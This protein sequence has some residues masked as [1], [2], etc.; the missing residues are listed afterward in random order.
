MNLCVFALKGV[1]VSVRVCGREMDGVSAEQKRVVEFMCERRS[2]RHFSSTP[3]P[4]DVC[5]LVFGAGFGGDIN[6]L[7]AMMVTNRS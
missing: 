1:C 3:I 4:V 7:T 5:C 2:V 6:I